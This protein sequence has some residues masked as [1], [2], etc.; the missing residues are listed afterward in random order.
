[1]QRIGTIFHSS[2]RVCLL[3]IVLAVVQSTVLPVLFTNPLPEMQASA[4]YHHMCKFWYLCTTFK[5][6]HDERSVYSFGRAYTHG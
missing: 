5:R 1:M 4:A 3:S 6:K 2:D